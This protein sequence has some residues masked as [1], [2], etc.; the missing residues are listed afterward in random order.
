MKNTYYVPAMEQENAT[1]CYQEV[2]GKLE[3]DLYLLSLGN[4]PESE[5]C[6]YVTTLITQ[7][8][9][10]ELNQ[11]LMFWMLDKPNHMPSDCRYEY[12]YYP[13][14][15]ASTILMN[16]YVN[17]DAVREIDGINE[18][19]KKVRESCCGRNMNLSTANTKEALRMYHIFAI[20]DVLTFIQAFPS[21]NLKFTE[22]FM[23]KYRWV[24]GYA[25]YQQE[26]D[27]ESVW[28]RQMARAIVKMLDKGVD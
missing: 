22:Q 1:D 10:Y 23:G 14:Y 24:Q 25:I 28:K 6:K 15:L 19:L 26:I 7:C 13:T 16:A 9:E 4:E 18:V 3:N 27:Y 2:I 21:M 17:Y 5:V 8:E 11:E 12:V 20:G